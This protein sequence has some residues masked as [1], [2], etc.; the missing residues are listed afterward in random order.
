MMRLLNKT[1]LV[2][3]ASKGIGRAIAIGI[4]REAAHVNVNYNTDRRRVNSFAFR[5]SIGLKQL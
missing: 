1:A 4:A 2:T 5:S 3:G